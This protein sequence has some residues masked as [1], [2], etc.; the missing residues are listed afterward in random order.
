MNE[1]SEG[2]LTILS[3]SEVD[4]DSL[5]LDRLSLR[6]VFAEGDLEIH[7]NPVANLAGGYVLY[8]DIIGGDSQSV[9][10]MLSLF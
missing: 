10:A 6:V 2:H 1:I 7:R 9:E 8:V 3:S 5:E 4:A